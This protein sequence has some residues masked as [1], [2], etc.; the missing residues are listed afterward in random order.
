MYLL[1][2]WSWE[3]TYWKNNTRV[4]TMCHTLFVLKIEGWKIQTNRGPALID[5]MVIQ[6][7]HKRAHN[8]SFVVMTK[9]DFLEE[10]SYRKKKR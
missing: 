6:A 2:I 3:L 8:L 9:E 1:V 5:K 7:A 4:P 10:M